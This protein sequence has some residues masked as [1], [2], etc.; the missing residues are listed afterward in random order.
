MA[1][2]SSASP[3][4]E[5]VVDEIG[6]QAVIRSV[7]DE[8]SPVEATDTRTSACPEQAVRVKG[9]REDRLTREAVCGTKHPDGRPLGVRSC[10]R[11]E[12][13]GRREERERSA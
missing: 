9:E 13:D 1:I 11:S 4:L 2:Q 7:V 3:A 8:F 10:R 5:D 6:R 12:E